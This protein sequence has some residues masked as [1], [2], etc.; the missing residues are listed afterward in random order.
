MANSKKIFYFTATWCPPC[1]RIA[2]IFESLSAE[3]PDI[4]F[5]KIDVDDL[6][7]AASFGNIRSVPTF[8]FRTG[9]TKISE[10]T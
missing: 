5:V 2:P 6:P 10:V 1:K 7:D 9:D 4:F 3:Y 8:H